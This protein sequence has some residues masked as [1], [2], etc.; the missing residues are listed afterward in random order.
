MKCADRK[1]RKVR[2]GAIAIA[3]AIAL[4][5]ELFADGDLFKVCFGTESASIGVLYKHTPQCGAVTVFQVLENG[6]LARMHKMFSPSKF[7]EEKV[8]FVRMRTDGLVDGAVLPSGLYRCV[9]ATN[10]ETAMGAVKTVSA[11]VKLSGEEQHKIYQERQEAE[12]R[13][14]KEQRESAIKEQ[15]ERKKMAET[16]IGNVDLNM[17]CVYIEKEIAPYFEMRVKNFI[18]E[19]LVASKAKK[20]YIAFLNAADDII[21]NRSDYTARFDLLPSENTMQSVCDALRKHRFECD[22]D[23]NKELVFLVPNANWKNLINSC[24]GGTIG[25]S[26]GVRRVMYRTADG[27]GEIFKPSS[28]LSYAKDKYGLAVLGD[29]MIIIGA[30]GSVEKYSRNDLKD[31]AEGLSKRIANREISLSEFKT[32]MLAMDKDAWQKINEELIPV[33][34]GAELDRIREMDKHLR[35]A[36]QLQTRQEFIDEVSK[37]SFCLGDYIVFQKGLLEYTHS[38]KVDEMWCSMSEFQEAGDWDAIA[39]MALGS[40]S[41]L[42]DAQQWVAA[43]K[44]LLSHEFRFQLFFTR[45]TG[46]YQRRR[47]GH[48]ERSFCFEDTLEISQ[49]LDKSDPVYVYV[50]ER[51]GDPLQGK[52]ENSKFDF[53][54]WLNSHPANMINSQIGGEFTKKSWTGPRDVSPLLKHKDAELNAVKSDLLRFRS[55]VASVGWPLEYLVVT[56]VSVVGGKM[57][58][59]EKK[60]TFKIPQKVRGLALLLDNK[61][62]VELYGKYCGGLDPEGFKGEWKDAGM[63]QES[64]YKKYKLAFEGIE[65][66]MLKALES[67]DPKARS[68]FGLPMSLED[69]ANRQI[70]YSM[71]IKQEQ[72]RSSVGK[73]AN[74]VC[75]NCRGR[76]YVQA[77]VECP[78]CGGAGTTYTPAKKLIQGYSKP[79]TSQCSNC[80]GRG[81]IRKSVPCL[82]CNR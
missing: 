21:N 77:E 59:T 40:S 39:R 35:S 68:G 28:V 62:V 19:R 24:K 63:K 13:F 25:V 60:K 54:D 69:I 31:R 82:N 14:A 79:R 37:L 3:C 71:P 61:D 32:E 81:T 78:K 30:K 22:F 1:S 5:G 49:K 20:D 33:P 17:G 45:N 75:D 48:V 55:A 42:S 57:V 16:I 36:R 76:K 46:Y 8:I 38:V 29:E 26:E 2:I 51:F 70:N 53:V 52:A 50:S 10:Y 65:K 44:N 73:T 9:G 27:S 12:N 11:F 15:P 18:W 47:N 67:A 41:D 72:P 6:V 66:S 43:K 56:N 23:C 74:P 80:S 7:V 34:R 58:Y 64:V 4:V